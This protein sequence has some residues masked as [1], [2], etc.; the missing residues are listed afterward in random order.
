MFLICV[1]NLSGLLGDI[2][3]FLYSRVC[4]RL[5]F[6]KKK[7]IV[8]NQD[9]IQSK[10]IDDKAK[11]ETN[12]TTLSSQWNENEKNNQKSYKNDA[13]II[14]DT[15]LIQKDF[16]TEEEEEEEEEKISVPLTITIIIMAIYIIVGAF[17]FN[18]SEG[19][20]LVESAYFCFITV[21]TIGL[22]F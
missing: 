20:S 22:Q 14:D 3:R 13:K 5:C 21:A 12:N 2:V 8:K 4:C 18:L 11:V 7:T 17:L 15:E 1:T 9:Q 6:K 19:W 10:N 16:N